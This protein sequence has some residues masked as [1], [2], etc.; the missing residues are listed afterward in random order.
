ML[1]STSLVALVGVGK[2]QSSPRTLKLYNTK[3]KSHICSLN[4]KSTIVGIK[5]NKLRFVVAV[6]KQ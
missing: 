3:N 6:T 2:P 4:F 1:F 5:M